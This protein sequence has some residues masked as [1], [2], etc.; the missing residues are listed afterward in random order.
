MSVLKLPDP[1]GWQSST[2]RLAVATLAGGA[3]C[4]GWLGY[5]VRSLIREHYL[6]VFAVFSMAA[7]FAIVMVALHLVHWGRTSLRA[8]TA[9]EGTKFQ[10]DPTFSTLMV[11]GMLVGIAGSLVLAIYVPRGGID[12]PMSQ[13]MQTFSPFI[14]WFGVAT[15]VLGLYTMLRRG[16]VGYVELTTDG[17]DIANAAFTESVQWDD[18]ADV[19]DVAESKKTRKAVVFELQDGREKVIDGADFYVPGGTAFYWM[20]R[21]YWR[22]PEDRGELSDERALDRLARNRFVAS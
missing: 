9:P 6:T 8:A 10:P 18:I 5:G 17:I 21:H 4:L 22:H 3:L 11:I 19:K 14:A 20:M 13:G 7:C 2:R 16:G 12:I 1:Q 15:G